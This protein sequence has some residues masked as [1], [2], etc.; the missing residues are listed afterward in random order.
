MKIINENRIKVLQR[1][2]D[3]SREKEIEVRDVSHDFYITDNVFIDKWARLCGIYG[4]GVYA[5]LK[6]HASWRDGT[7]FPSIELIAEKLEISVTMVQRGVQSLEK[8]GIIAVERRRGERSLY[9]LTEK[10]KWKE[11][12]SYYKIGRMR[13][14]TKGER[15]GIVVK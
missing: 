11:P 5:A 6:R 2:R 1:V 13:K 4:A 15:A 14:A 12:G 7:C 10:S 8:L 3:K 9:F